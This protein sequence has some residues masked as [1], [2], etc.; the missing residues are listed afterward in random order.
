MAL[1]KPLSLMAMLVTRRASTM[2]DPSGG[3]LT[4]FFWPEMNTP[5]EIM[6]ALAESVPRV[7][8]LWERSKTYMSGIR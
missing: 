4:Y 1:A 8:L 3:T 5:A 6:I 7:L 2:A